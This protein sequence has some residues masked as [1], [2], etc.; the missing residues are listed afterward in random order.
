MVSIVKGK[1]MT[2]KTAKTTNS[3]YVVLRNMAAILPGLSGQVALLN[4]LIN[5]VV[6]KRVGQVT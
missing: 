6:Q 2:R 3:D 5:P 1:I 4:R